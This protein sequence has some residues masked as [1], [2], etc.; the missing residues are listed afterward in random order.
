MIALNINA[1]IGLICHYLLKI[2]DPSLRI[3]MKIQQLNTNTNVPYLLATPGST[4]NTEFD[5]YG[6]LLAFH[7]PFDTLIGEQIA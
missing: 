4:F 7:F 5:Y 3:N 1:P 2:L 6:Q